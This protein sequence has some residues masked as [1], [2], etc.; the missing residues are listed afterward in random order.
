MW[1]FNPEGQ[2]TIQHFFGMTPEGMYRLFFESR[3]KC[4]NTIEDVGLNCNRPDTQVGNS[5][6]ERGQDWLSKAE[7]I[8]CPAPLPEGSPSPA[9]A[10]MLRRALS[11]VPSGKDEGKNKEAELHTLHIH[12]GGTTTSSKEDNRGGESKVPS[13]QG[14]KR[15]A[16]ED[17]EVMVSKRGKN[18]LSVG[19]TPEAILTAQYPQGDQPSTEL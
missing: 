17:L 8:M 13:P 19:P 7:R 10:R 9:I 3:I 16:S 14:R 12:T 5:T 2:R 4:P 15:T 6:T 1:E 18:P 11:Q